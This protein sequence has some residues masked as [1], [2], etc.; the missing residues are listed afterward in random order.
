VP[1]GRGAGVRPRS[2][3]C[4]VTS[5]YGQS[6]SEAA[7]SAAC[8]AR[9][10]MSIRRHQSRR[11][12]WRWTR[13]HRGTTQR[14]RRLA[15]WHVVQTRVRMRLECSFCSVRSTLSIW[16]VGEGLTTVIGHRERSAQRERYLHLELCGC[17]SR[18]RW[19]CTWL[20]RRGVESVLYQRKAAIGRDK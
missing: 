2:R 20:L 12:R 16:S 15:R 13:Q 10:R 18:E 17:S 4:P 14:R 19:R 8:A 1:R 6:S 5:L 7:T 3:T 11:Y 9:A